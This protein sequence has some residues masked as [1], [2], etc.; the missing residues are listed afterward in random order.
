M[1]D[2]WA[3]TILHLLLLK[4]STAD[5]YNNLND[6]ATNEHESVSDKIDIKVEKVQ[7]AKECTDKPYFAKCDL[8][9]KANFCNKNPYYAEFCCQSCT[10][11]GQLTQTP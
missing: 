2:H 7:T 11:A 4:N 3:N 10:S 9:V 5:P 6:R 8:I 1:F